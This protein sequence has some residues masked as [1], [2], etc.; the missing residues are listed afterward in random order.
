MTAGLVRIR[1]GRAAEPEG[2][3]S[4]CMI[5]HRRGCLR[6]LCHVVL[7]RRICH[8]PRREA[9]IASGTGISRLW[10]GCPI[11]TS[12]VACKAHERRRN[13]PSSQWEAVAGVAYRPRCHRARCCHASGQRLRRSL[14]Q[15]PVPKDGRSV[16]MARAFCRLA[17]QPRGV[18]ADTGVYAVFKEQR[19]ERRISLSYTSRKIGLFRTG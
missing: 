4:C 8:S 11:P 5:L 18:C 7:F 2:L 15:P 19:R 9:Y 16:V 14:G 3:L 13:P 1:S 6:M 12:A 10:Q 17:F